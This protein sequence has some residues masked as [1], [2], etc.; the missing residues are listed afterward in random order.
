MSP[1]HFK[2]LSFANVGCSDLHVYKPS[3]NR[4]TTPQTGTKDHD[5]VR[6]NNKWLEG[7]NAT[8]IECLQCY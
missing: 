7:E 2:M 6:D 3:P 5:L 1:F 8:L 4:P